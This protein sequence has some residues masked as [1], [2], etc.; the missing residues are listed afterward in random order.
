MRASFFLV[1]VTTAHLTQIA[2]MIDAGELIPH[3]GG[4][5]ALADARIAHEMLEGERPRPGGKIVLRV[6]E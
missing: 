2:G 1:N 6:G 3:V 5:L 4:V